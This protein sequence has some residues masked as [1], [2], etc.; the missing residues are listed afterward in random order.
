MALA[1]CLV[2]CA[3]HPIGVRAQSYDCPAAKLPVEQIICHDK[4]LQTLDLSL[5]GAYRTAL[6]TTADGRA[7]MED[8]RRWLRQRNGARNAA[9]L[10]RLYNE[11]ISALAASPVV[12]KVTYRNDA[13]GLTLK[14]PSNRTL[15]A[16]DGK[17]RCIEIHGSEFGHVKML[18]RLQEF[19]KPLEATARDE[20]GFQ[21]DHGQWMTTYGRFGPAPVE[22]FS[23]TGW[24][25]MKAV[26]TCGIS[27]ENGFHA[28]AGECF[29]AVIS[30][31]G[32]SIVASTEGDSDWRRDASAILQT[33]T[34]T[35]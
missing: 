8:Q 21:R 24:T 28:A 33:V 25:G 30:Q 2:L 12:G 14:M 10:V 31:G 3:A 29:W 22:T 17:P 19:D 35:R 20:A 9:A 18:L 16:C 27:D 15:R 7:V 23:G 13:L 1:T 34:L 11:R 6:D 32:H 4:R 26:I 5:D